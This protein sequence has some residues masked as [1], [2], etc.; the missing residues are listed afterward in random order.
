MTTR[1]LDF[2][3]GKWFTIIVRRLYILNLTMEQYLLFYDLTI[4]ATLSLWNWCTGCV[5]G[6]FAIPDASSCFL[7]KTSLLIKS[8]STRIVIKLNYLDYT[9][10]WL[11][12]NQ[13]C[14]VFPFPVAPF[15][16]SHDSS[17]S[18]RPP[19]RVESLRRPSL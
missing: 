6:S 10:S 5:S 1:P 9:P 3:I 12:C 19:W 15:L 17:P 4:P 18:E 8:A 14:V 11:C 16:I 2:S 7:K 13:P